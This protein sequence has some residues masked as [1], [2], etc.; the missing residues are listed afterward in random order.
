MEAKKLTD[1]PEYVAAQEKLQSLI[2]EQSAVAQSVRNNLGDLQRPASTVTSEAAM[3]LDGGDLETAS[4]E[5]TQK[6]HTELNHHLMVLGEAVRLQRRRV[7]AARES[8]SRKVCKTL[9][10]EWQ[11]FAKTIRD[12]APKLADVGDRQRVFL[13]DLEREGI[14]LPQEWRQSSV[15]ENMTWKMRELS[16]LC[17][18]AL[19]A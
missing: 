2:A 4:G 7:N 1:V 3:L 10:P 15:D 5:A 13:N 12:L 9:L 19:R 8:A 14:M 17:D 16:K 18:Q 6:Q 11:Q